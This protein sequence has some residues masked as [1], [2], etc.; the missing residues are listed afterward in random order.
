MLADRIRAAVVCAAVSC[1]LV[2]PALAADVQH[3]SLGYDQPHTIGQGTQQ[4]GP[5][6]VRI[7]LAPPLRGPHQGL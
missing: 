5:R 4:K 3:D 7:C 6:D 1:G 2:A